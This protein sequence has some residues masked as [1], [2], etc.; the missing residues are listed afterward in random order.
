VLAEDAHKDA[1]SGTLVEYHLNQEIQPKGFRDLLLSHVLNEIESGAFD[2][3]LLD[4]RQELVL[5]VEMLKLEL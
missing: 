3:L 4:A 2:E 5:V 1:E